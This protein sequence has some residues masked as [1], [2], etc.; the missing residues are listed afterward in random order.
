MDANAF[1]VSGNQICL[2]SNGVTGALSD[3]EVPRWQR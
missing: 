3:A 2:A 1:L